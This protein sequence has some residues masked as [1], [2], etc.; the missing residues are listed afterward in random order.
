MVWPTLGSRKAKEQNRTLDIVKRSAIEISRLTCVEHYLS[1]ENL[2]SENFSISVAR[3][4]DTAISF[5]VQMA[6][7]DIDRSDGV[8]RSVYLS[9]SGGKDSKWITAARSNS[10]TLCLLRR[11]HSFF[12]HPCNPCVPQEVF[13]SQ[14]RRL[15]SADRA[16]VN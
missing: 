7:S 13:G 16:H 12:Q 5:C 2:L 14:P 4:S 10:L 6:R 9:A 15:R 1:F 11:H 3:D 8:S